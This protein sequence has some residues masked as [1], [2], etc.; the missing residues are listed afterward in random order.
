MQSGKLLAV[1]FLV[2]ASL[3]PQTVTQAQSSTPRL[4]PLPPVSRNLKTG[5]EIGQRIPNFRLED[6]SGRLRDFRSLAGRNG[7][8]LAFVRSADW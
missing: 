4:H 8:L 1:T 6:Q 2:G 7:L 5:P 3:L